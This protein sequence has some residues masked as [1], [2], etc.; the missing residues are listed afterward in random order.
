MTPPDH[1]TETLAHYTNTTSITVGEFS[2]S[3]GMDEKV[4]GDT[5]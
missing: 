3:S 4:C 5:P 1:I 2:T